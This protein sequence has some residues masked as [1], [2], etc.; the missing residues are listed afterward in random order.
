MRITWRA[1]RD[2]ILYLV[3]LVTRRAL[4]QVSHDVL[5]GHFPFAVRNPK[6]GR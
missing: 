5:R 2:I 6:G 4:N 1:L 3:V